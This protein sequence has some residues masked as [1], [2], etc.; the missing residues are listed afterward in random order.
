MSVIG[1]GPPSVAEDCLGQPIV[2]LAAPEVVH[3]VPPAGSDL[4]DVLDRARVD[5]VV[6]RDPDLLAYAVRAGHLTAPLAWDRTY[7]LFTIG[8]G[9]DLAMPAD[10]YALARDA[11]TAD[12]TPAGVGPRHTGPVDVC[13]RPDTVRRRDPERVVAY[14]AGDAIGQQLAERIAAV[15]WV[16]RATRVLPVA[17]DSVVEALARW[18][19]AAAVLAIPRGEPAV[20]GATTAVPLVDSRAHAIVRRG[21]GAAFVVGRDG[22]LW[23][24]KRGAP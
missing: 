10:A 5:V 11:V 7:V 3:V 16:P 23:F 18:Q 12:V 2:G 9:T 21:S 4:R 22:G 8:A 6:T 14:P 24:V 15:G 20:C 17:G 19:V 13:A 1:I